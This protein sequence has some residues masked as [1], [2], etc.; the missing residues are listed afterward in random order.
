MK[1][2]HKHA[3][4]IKAWADGAIIEVFLP[5]H[6]WWSKCY[7]NPNWVVNDEYRIQPEPV[8][9]IIPLSNLS[10]KDFCDVLGYGQA[11]FD[12]GVAYAI[13]TVKP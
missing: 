2:P 13:A 10:I 3:E 6:N 7:G 5:Y 11:C 4:L 1:E 12:A 9:P 8:L